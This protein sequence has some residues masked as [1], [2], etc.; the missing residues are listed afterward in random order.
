M[1]RPLLWLLTLLITQLSPESRK[2]ASSF[3]LPEESTLRVRQDAAAG[4]IAI[5]RAGQTEPIVTQHARP[6]FRP[7]LHPIAAPDGK[8]VLTEYSPGH[9]KHQT[10]LYWGYTR[11]N[12]RDYFHNPQGDYWRRVS[13]TVVEDSGSVVKWQTVYDLLDDKGQPV[14]RETQDWALR[15]KDGRFLLDL[16]WNGEALTDI[17]IGKY[18]YGGLF[19][20]MPWKEG[21]RGEVINAARQRNEKA[22]GQ[23]AMWVDVAMQVAGRDDLAHVAIF[24]HPENK[25]YPQTWR[26]DNQLGVGPARAR[27]GDWHIKKGETETIRHQV[28]AYTGEL[29][30]VA[31][32]KAWGEYAGNNSMYSTVALWQLAQKEGREAKFLTP[33]EAVA[34]M[35]AQPGYTVNAWAAEPM[36]TQPMAFCW[37]DRGRLWVAENRDYEARGKGF[38]NAGDSRILILEDTNGDGVADSRKVFLEGIAFPAALAVGFDG[39]FVGAPPNLLFVPDRNHDDKAD[40]DNIEVRLTGWGIRDR[41]ETL[42]SFHWGPDGWLYGCQGFATP[43]KV[44]KPTGKGRLY[45]HKDAFPEDILQGEGVD[46]NGG[47]WRYHPTKDIFEVVAHGFSN[48]WGIDY[49]A[50]GQLFISACV[51]PH[52]WHVVPGGIYHRQGGQHFNPYVYQDIKTIADHS[53]RSA[54][55]GARIYQSDAFPAEQRG[56]IFMANIHEHAV[57]SDVLTPQGSG[58]TA[59]HGQD[60]LLANNA[61]WVGFSLEIGPEGGLYVLDWHD[62]DICGSEVL[63]QETGRIYRIMPEKS[64]A[65][66]WKN[67]Y[68][69]LSKLPDAQLVELQ[70][71]PSEWH[72]RRARLILQ[73]RAAQGKLRAGTHAALRTLYRTHANPDWRLRAF[74]ALHV[75]NGLSNQQLLEALTDRDA[76]VRAWAVQFLGE[77]QVP[78]AQVLAKMTQLAHTDPSPVVRLYLASALQRLPVAARWELASALMAHGEDAQDHNLPKMIWYGLEPLVAE[79]PAR[80]L[81]LASRSEIPLLA[82]LVARR[83]V[84]ANAT[85]TLVAALG[86]KPKALPSL[87][88]GMRDGLEGRSDLKAPANWKTVYASLR[89][90]DAPTA[91]LALELAQHFGDTEAAG[92]YL[93]TLKDPKVPLEQRRK[94][95]QAL[96]A[97]QR[98]ELLKELPTLLQDAGLRLDAIRA[99]AGY[100]HEPLGKLLLANYPT[101]SPAEKAEAVQALAS[102][103][104]YGWLL[105]QAIAKNEVPK[106]D[107]PVYLARQLR[108]VVGSGFVEVWGPIDHV[109]LDEKAYSRYRK[110]LTEPALAQANPRQG[111]VLFQQTCGPCH[112]M[113]GEGGTLGPDITGS[114]RANLDYLLSNILDPS[115]EIQDDYKMVVV[116][117]RDGRTYVGN[118]AK[119]TERQLTLRIVGQDAVVI[120]KSEVQTREVTPT[121]MMPTG[122]LE[123]LTDTEIKNLVAYLRTTAQVP[124]P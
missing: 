3:V 96:T 9:H 27:S 65:Q 69:D 90:S 66:N 61:Q 44:R 16:E 54:H 81:Q 30:D 2:T 63:Q 62:A 82:Q 39:V 8:G 118:V 97:Q 57:L 79:N 86:Q 11:V 88:A 124:L 116:T 98:P 99:V 29:N 58:F 78:S 122:L 70:T 28:V 87:L 7:Y 21:I 47:V 67:R 26:V 1:S 33:Q 55:G 112:R 15:E 52:L 10:G 85:E 53:H 23:R 37:D 117:T 20:R 17:T 121:S 119:E 71:S 76:H 83:A 105:T 25:G 43:S 91:Q 59:Q 46:I 120:N 123:P 13:A 24:D 50:K 80:A 41:H 109:A 18:D 49:D 5:Y 74:W 108:R 106:R 56:R 14:L 72:A 95:L 102:R 94:A 100:D 84:D 68:A 38:S 104:R 35:T 75:T 19:L 110:L 32:T 4:T 73:H 92:Q 89:Q 115:G 6:D 36:I 77:S 40:V 42:N 34:A 101:F 51:I 12:G 45:R 103:P 93:T 114:N 64:L 22:E 31:L 48:P 111:R 107:V 60:F 113:Y